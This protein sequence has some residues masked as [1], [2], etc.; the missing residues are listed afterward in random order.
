MLIHLV[1]LSLFCFLFS[2]ARLQ[3]VQ[4]VRWHFDL[5]NFMCS[6]D[7]PNR[8]KLFFF[9]L[10]TRNHKYFSVCLFWH[11]Q[12]VI[13]IAL[14]AGD[15]SSRRNRDLAMR[16]DTRRVAR[17][18]P[19]AGTGSSPDVGILITETTARWNCFQC[20]VLLWELHLGFYPCKAG[21]EQKD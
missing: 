6:D 13:Y 19:R 10:C 4:V 17:E 16:E 1:I 8:S 9:L 18:P 3:I 21:C 11:R 15:W 7:K 14:A 5:R 2:W 20:S 12:A